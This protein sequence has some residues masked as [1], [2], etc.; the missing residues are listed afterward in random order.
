[1]PIKNRPALTINHEFD[2][3]FGQNDDEL[4]DYESDLLEFPRRERQKRRSIGKNI[5]RKRNAIT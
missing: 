4:D 1:M 5:Y 2:L 3:V